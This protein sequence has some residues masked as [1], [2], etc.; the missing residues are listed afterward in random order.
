M[1]GVNRVYIL[2]NL[3]RD[4]EVRYLSSGSAIANFSVATTEQ[5]RD[6]T[7]NE[8]KSATEWHKC[9]CFGR[10]AEIAGEYLKKGSKVFVEGSLRTRPWEK[11]GQTHY[12]TEINVRELQMIGGRQDSENAGSDRPAEAR[13]APRAQTPG[14]RARQ[15]QS[16]PQG[17]D[18][19]DMEI[20]FAP[21]MRD[22]R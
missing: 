19:F 18:D 1:R 15:Q 7:T 17:G 16:A 20:P 10:L 12:S 21:F 13:P 8:V 5:W 22:E 9:Q 6:K 4:P 11:D 2:G 14:Q 3:G